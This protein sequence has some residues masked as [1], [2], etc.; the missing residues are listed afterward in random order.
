MGHSRVTHRGDAG[1]IMFH[2]TECLWIKTRLLIIHMTSRIIMSKSAPFIHMAVRWKTYKRVFKGGTGFQLSSWQWLVMAAWIRE[3]WVTQRKTLGLP[4]CTTW[5]HKYD[6]SFVTWLRS[7][8]APRCFPTLI[9]PRPILILVLQRCNASQAL[10]VSNVV[11]SAGAE[12]GAFAWVT[13]Q[14]RQTAGTTVNNL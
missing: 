6:T 4:L 8:R 3:R 7:I 11:V 9:I 13:S 10:S 12:Q 5:Q 14:D 1:W 2:R